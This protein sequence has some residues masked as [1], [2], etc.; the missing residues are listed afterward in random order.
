MNITDE[1]LKQVIKDPYMCGDVKALAMATEL[2][3]RRQGERELVEGLNQIQKDFPDGN[4]SDFGRGYLSGIQRASRVIAERSHLHATPAEDKPATVVKRCDN[5]RFV[6]VDDFNC[7]ADAPCVKH[8]M[9][10][11]KPTGW[12]GTAGNELDAMM[13]KWDKPA[14]TSTPE[15]K[16]QEAFDLI[17]ETYAAL[18]E[19]R[20]EGEGIW[21]S[22][23]KQTLKRRKPGFS[24]SHGIT[25]KYDGF[26]PF[27][28]WSR[29]YSLQLHP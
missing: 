24:E 17:L 28:P 3:T 18:V 13:E 19:E 7:T 20:G 12:I 5:C 22:M 1:E 27:S 4:L 10:Q 26:Y 25:G 16:R 23:I 2:L 8:S 14:P 11:A 9:W 15:D 29:G 21:G 6:M